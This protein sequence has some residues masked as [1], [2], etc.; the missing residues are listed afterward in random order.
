MRRAVRQREPCSRCAGQPALNVPPRG[1]RLSGDGTM[2]SVFGRMISAAQFRA[3]NASSAL[4]FWALRLGMRFRLQITCGSGAFAGGG[5]ASRGDMTV[6]K[7]PFEGEAE[8]VVCGSQT[9]HSLTPGAIS[10]PH[11]GQIQWNINSIYT[12]PG[13]MP[14]S[15]SPYLLIRSTLAGLRF[16]LRTLPRL[17][18]E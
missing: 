1:W 18:N 2:A 7:G 13:E 6:A 11:S 8:P 17:F 3:Q 5:D 4:H 12:E 14:V 9:G 15:Y 16:N 10:W